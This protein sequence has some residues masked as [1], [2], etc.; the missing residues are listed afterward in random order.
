MGKPTLNPKKRQMFSN[1]FKLRI[2]QLKDKGW[3]NSELCKEFKLSSSTCATMYSAKS[4]ETVKKAFEQLVNENTVVNNPF[5][6]AAVIHDVEWIMEYY[7]NCNQERNVFLTESVICSKALEVFET[8]MKNGLFHIDGSRVSKGN[9]TPIYVGRKILGKRYEVQADVQADEPVRNVISDQSDTDE[10]T[11]VPNN[12]RISRLNVRNV[13]SEDFHLVISDQSDTDEPTDVPNN[14]SIS[15]LNVRNVISEESDPDELT[16][17]PITVS[18]VRDV[19]VDEAGPSTNKK[20]LFFKFSH[21]WYHRFVV[22]KLGY[23]HKKKHG[24][25]ASADKQAVE[26]FV[27]ELT[28]FILKHYDGPEYIYNVDEGGLF[29]KQILNCCVDTS[30]KSKAMSGFKKNKVRATVLM[31]GML[32]ERN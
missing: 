29:Y 2:I 10:P 5:L 3:K 7:L 26:K 30:D 24:E 27:P 6:K 15:R 8:L 31:G 16:E 25:A 17:A 4:R 21:G 28:K 11:D 9:P 13:I 1:K 23:R 14:S 22:K 18:S 32:L 19:V 20:Q 12:S